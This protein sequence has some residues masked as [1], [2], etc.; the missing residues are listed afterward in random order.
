MLA[1]VGVSHLFVGCLGPGHSLVCRRLAASVAVLCEVRMCAV[2]QR[3]LLNNVM[4]AVVSV[5]S[6]GGQADSL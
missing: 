5:G 1:K 2:A 3:A 6:W 4:F